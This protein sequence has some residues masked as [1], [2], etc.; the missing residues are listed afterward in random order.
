M[1]TTATATSAGGVRRAGSSRVHQ[2]VPRRLP[3]GATRRAHPLGPRR[4]G[5]L[6]TALAGVVGHQ[7]AKAALLG[8][9]ID[10]DLRSRVGRWPRARRR[11]RGSTC[12]PQHGGGRRRRRPRR[13]HGDRGRR[14]RA[15]HRSVKL[16]ITPTWDRSPV[17]AVPPPGPSSGSRSTRMVRTPTPR[18]PRRRSAGSSA[19]AGGSLDYVEQPLPADDLVGT[20]VL[21]RQVGVPIALDESVGS[22]GEACTA[23]AIGAMGML[24]VKPARVGGPIAA[25]AVAQVAA[26]EG[27]PFSAGACSRVAWDVQRRWHSPGIPSAPDR[28]TW[29]RRAG[30]WSTTSP[31]RSRWRTG[32]CAYPMVPVSASIPTSRRSSGAPSSAGR[33]EPGRRGSLGR[34]HRA[35]HG[36]RGARPPDSRARHPRALVL[37]ADRSRHRAGQHAG[38][39]R[40]RP[41]RGRPTR[42]RRRTSSERGR[43]GVRRPDAATWSTTCCPLETLVGTT[44]SPR[45]RPGWGGAAPRRSR[46]LGVDADEPVTTATRTR[47]S[48]LVCFAGLGVG[49]VTMCAR[50]RWGSPSVGPAT[51][52]DSR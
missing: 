12:G 26:E 51:R 40:A 24:N 1:R 33:G 3:S 31:R 38:R 48:P 15:G 18:S 39:R 23:L 9:L 34:P 6:T 45:P 10:L 21:A 17:R 52:L 29:A 50:R 49:E 4:P 41:R 27:D 47:W 25:V 42:A 32:A 5:E 43:R 35:G 36:R 8:A 28:P 30:T 46:D 13:A 20:A 16:K 19:R 14:V 37:Q 2:R 7:M 44:T 22:I 11:R